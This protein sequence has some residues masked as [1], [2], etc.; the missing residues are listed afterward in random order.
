MTEISSYPTYENMNFETTT[1]T[2]ALKPNKLQQLMQ[3]PFTL[4]RVATLSALVSASLI[5]LWIIISA[6]LLQISS[7]MIFQPERSFH[8]YPIEQNYKQMFFDLEDGTT[9]DAIYRD[10]P[11]ASNVILYLH[12]N[13]GR[14]PHFFL[15]FE[16][17]FD[18]YSPANPGFHFSEGTPN[19]KQIFETGEKAYQQ[20]LDMGY[21]E[22]QIIIYG[23]SLGGP[24]ATHLARVR[25]NARGLVLVNAVSSVRQ[26]CMK[27]YS[28]FCVFSGDIMNGIKEAQNI[29]PETPVYQYHLLSDTTVP[30]EEGKKLFDANT[31]NTKIFTDLDGTTHSTFN[32]QQTLER[33][34]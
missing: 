25:P 4:R 16:K 9:I 27:T 31:S 14:I 24:N 33:V 8:I 19:T 23:H 13:S 29:N 6:L 17:E 34:K 18:Y 32:I 5:L 10:S 21:Q 15:D 7:G 26:I 3:S 22:N 2:T 1:A 11:R 12:G 30:Y 20:L 28:I